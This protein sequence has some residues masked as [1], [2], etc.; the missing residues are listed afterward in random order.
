MTSSKSPEQSSRRTSIIT[1]ASIGAV[2]VAGLFAI[3][4]NLGILS[5]TNQT[6]VG[7]VS[8]AGDLIPIDTRVVDQT[9]DTGGAVG[10]Q[11]FTVDEAGSVDVSVGTEGAQLDRMAP[12][13]GWTATQETSA[14]ADVAVAFTDGTRTFEFT[15]V[16]GPDGTIVGDVAEPSAPTTTPQSSDDH[17]D[18]KSDDHKSDD[19]HDDHGSD[20]HHYEGADDDD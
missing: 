19:H 7:T 5:T 16:I 11:H 18:H 13:D 15:A 2:G 9:S 6:S 14:G 17:D 10:F 1:A 8:A 3:G 4:A 12:A 20:D